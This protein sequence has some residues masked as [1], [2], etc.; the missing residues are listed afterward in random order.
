MT[1]II[2]I[3]QFI[4]KIHLSCKLLVENILIELDEII[5]GLFAAQ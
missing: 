5:H 3:V 2:L 4:L 1:I